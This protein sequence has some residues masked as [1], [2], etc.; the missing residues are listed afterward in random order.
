MD[1][2]RQKVRYS[3]ILKNIGVVLI[4]LLII[5]A[6]L[7]A[8]K[9]YRSVKYKE[10]LLNRINQEVL[11]DRGTG[12]VVAWKRGVS[13]VAHDNIIHDTAGWYVFTNETDQ[14]EYQKMYE[15]ENPVGSR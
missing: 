5:A 12:M 3:E 1:T 13:S 6:P 10:V 9:I 11:V 7:I 4:L 8:K 2:K 15:N 14:Q